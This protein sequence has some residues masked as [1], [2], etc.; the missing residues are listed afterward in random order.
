MSLTDTHCH[1]DFNKFDEDR[2]AVI[3]RAID[4]GITRMLIPALDLDSSRAAVRL[5]EV[6]P[7]IF[8]AVGFH[9]TDLDKWKETS[10]S[11]LRKLILDS[12]GLPLEIQKQASVPQ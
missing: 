5:A 6:H 7:N 11:D 8:A 10:Y 12:I 3:Q 4:I 2:Q 9:P 1:L